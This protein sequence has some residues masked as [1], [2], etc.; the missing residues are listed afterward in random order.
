VPINSP[1]HQMYISLIR[2]GNDPKSAAKIAQ[3]KTGI[4]LKTGRPIRA[5]KANLKRKYGKQ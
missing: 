4:A 1:A 5:Y 3:G 2:E